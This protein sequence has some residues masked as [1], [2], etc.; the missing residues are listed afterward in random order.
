MKKGLLT[1][2][3]FLA[4]TITST[5]NAQV[6]T[7]TEFF[8]GNVKLYGLDTDATIDSGYVG[9]NNVYGDVA[10]MQLFDATHG[11]VESGTI[12]SVLIAVPVK[13]D[14]GGSFQVCIWTDAAGTPSAIPVA[15][16][17][18]TLASVDTTLAGWNIAEATG[19]YNVVATFATPVTIPSNRKF[20][21]GVILPS[22]A[23]NEMALLTDSIGDFAEAVTHT[24]EFWNDATFH[25]FGDVNNW[26]IN[27][28]LAIFPV[29]NFAVNGLEE[30]TTTTASVY[31]NPAVNELN[32]NLNGKVSSITIL[33]LDGKVISTTNVNG[34]SASVNV[35]DLTS[36]IYMYQVNTLNGSVVT[37]KFV[38]K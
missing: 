18:I 16:K 17:N 10:K 25:T 21:A 36:G 9:G 27:C 37:N 32:F 23:G 14:G 26:G 3:A 38:K 7:L 13:T 6:D 31:P 2:G 20:W 29:V 24:G 34:T 5:L 11:V 4:L 1:M 12:T 35:S 30:N 19:F 33:S 8:S 15:T 22:T 28:A